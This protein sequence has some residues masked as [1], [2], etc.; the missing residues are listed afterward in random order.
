MENWKDDILS[1]M[2]GADRADVPAG[3]FHKIEQQIKA[4]K[5]KQLSPMRWLAVAAS[6]SAVVIGNLFFIMN[7]EQESTSVASDDAYPA[8]VTDFNI[9]GNE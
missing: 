2:K 4:Q 7:Y 8:L 3:A 6:I 5:Q 1:S 9:Y